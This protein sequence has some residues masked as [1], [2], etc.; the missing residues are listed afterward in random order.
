VASNREPDGN[1]PAVA[2]RTDGAKGVPAPVAITDDGL[3]RE[4]ERELVRAMRDRRRRANCELA[5]WC[6]MRI[7]VLAI[8]LLAVAQ[9][10]P[11]V[12][13]EALRLALGSVA[14]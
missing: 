14:R 12:A 1:K 7:A 4:H 9:G 6:L 13:L 3:K 8:G 5:V 11:E 2:K 10:A